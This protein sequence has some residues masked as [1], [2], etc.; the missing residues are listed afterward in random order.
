MYIE[1]KRINIYK[2][3]NRISSPRLMTPFMNKQEYFNISR[4]EE[5]AACIPVRFISKFED[6]SSMLLHTSS[7][8]MLK[9]NAKSQYV[10]TTLTAQFKIEDYDKLQDYHLY[11]HELACPMMLMLDNT[12][13]SYVEP[14]YTYHRIDI[15]P[16]ISSGIHEIKMM[17]FQ[18]R[19]DATCQYASS[20]LEDIYIMSRAYDRI[21]DFDVFCQYDS[22][23]A[24]L[25]PTIEIKDIEG[26]PYITYSVLDQFGE[27]L[28]V[29]EINID[30]SNHLNLQA[31]P[32][33]END[34]HHLTLMLETQDE[35][36]MHELMMKFVMPTTHAE[37][38][39]KVIAI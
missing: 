13:V 8:Q 31:I 9:E 15:T 21:E 34:L 7:H 19:H 22:E 5:A 25:Q 16:L 36:I 1:K 3:Q 32:L 12:I 39:T 2:N 4:K 28:T 11:I 33:E 27:T 14:D 20:L 37:H 17:V 24:T 18:E 30:Q 26:A 29:G 6:Y 35:V 23:I 38:P 10:C